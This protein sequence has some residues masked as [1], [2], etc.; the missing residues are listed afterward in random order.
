MSTQLMRR[1]SA[2]VSANGRRLRPVA[3]AAAIVTLIILAALIHQ[4]FYNNST[5]DTQTGGRSVAVPGNRA[6][7][8][9]TPS[10]WTPPPA[11]STAPI[12]GR[13]HNDSTPQQSA[14]SEPSADAV[15]ALEARDP[16]WASDAE[17]RIAA[18]V[19]GQSLRTYYDVRVECHLTQC[20]LIAT[21]D[22]GVINQLGP[23]ADW[24]TT[25]SAM[26]EDSSWKEAFDTETTK[27]TINESSGLVSFQSFLRRRAPPTTSD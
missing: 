3:T 5:L 18:V 20:R 25:L 8:S 24:E 17:T 19:D 14:A 2:Q 7:L 9:V 21:I 26:L 16:L 1:H 15:F 23:G 11:T 6:W 4:Y 10:A 12:I 13:A 27:Q 22:N